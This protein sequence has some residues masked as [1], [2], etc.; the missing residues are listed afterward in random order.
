MKLA[1]YVINLHQPLILSN[2]KEN[3][4]ENSNIYSNK[5]MHSDD[6]YKNLSN[7]RGRESDLSPSKMSVRRRDIKSSPKLP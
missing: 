1:S 2:N 3:N 5:E 4:K 7:L 6:K